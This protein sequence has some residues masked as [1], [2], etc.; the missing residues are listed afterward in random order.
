MHQTG[1]SRLCGVPTVVRSVTNGTIIHSYSWSWDFFEILGFNT[2]WFGS[3]RYDTICWAWMRYDHDCSISDDTICHDLV[4]PSDT[5]RYVWTGL[6]RSKPRYGVDLIQSSWSRFPIWD[7]VARVYTFW[8][9]HLEPIRSVVT[10]YDCG[11][12]VLHDPHQGYPRFELRLDP[13]GIYT[14]RMTIDFL[15]SFKISY[16]WHLCICCSH[17][18]S[19]WR[20]HMKLKHF[21]LTCL[22]S[23]WF[24][25]VTYFDTF[26]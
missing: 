3:I 5:I 9:V 6:S 4:S 21:L 14:A 18:E 22:W 19:C 8:C 10:G 17:I 7:D 25:Y 24:S 26:E 23:R 16:D 15:V 2:K 13:K 1:S 12:D 11:P 20:S